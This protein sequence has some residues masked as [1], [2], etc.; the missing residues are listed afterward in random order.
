MLGGRAA[1]GH[2]FRSTIEP[3]LD[4]L[5]N[6]LVLPAKDAS[7][8]RRGAK[9]LQ[10]AVFARVGP[11]AVHGL[12]VLNVREAIRQRLAGWAAIGVLLGSV[13]AVLLA[14]TAFRLGT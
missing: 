1:H 10:P 13:D 2:G 6:G 7:F 5:E 9:R 12:A 14:E 4:F 11:V 3:G 8:L